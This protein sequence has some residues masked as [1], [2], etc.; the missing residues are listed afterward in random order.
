MDRRQ[1][2]S[3]RRTRS[4]VRPVVDRA[5]RRGPGLQR[6]EALR[7]ELLEVRGPAVEVVDPLAQPG[8]DRL[9]V[10]GDRV[11][12]EVEAVVAVV[13][14]LDVRG[15]RAPRL[16]DDG[17][18]DEPRDDRPVGIGPDDRLVDELLDDDDDAVGGEGRLLLAAE[19]APDLG[20]AAGRGALGMDDRDVRLQRRD[21]VDPSRRR[22]ATRSA[23]SAGSRPAGRSRSRSAAGRTAGSSRPPCSARPSRSG[24]TPR[25]RAA[26]PGARPRSGG[27]SRRARRRR[28]CRATRRPASR[29]RRRRSS[30]RR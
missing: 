25:S 2:S 17:V 1:G 24:C 11:P 21:G 16:D 8:L 3:A 5:G 6:R 28:D 4:P 15:M 14:T 18:D 9:L 12:V 10:A 13:G 26:G 29:R 22:T 7:A 23:G 27:G 20:V 30:G 19:Q